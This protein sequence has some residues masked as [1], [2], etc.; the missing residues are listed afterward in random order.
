M[1]KAKFDGFRH[2]RWRY[3]LKVMMMMGTSPQKG[4]PSGLWAVLLPRRRRNL[5]L[6]FRAGSVEAEMF[7]QYS[8]TSKMR[9]VSC[10]K[11]ADWKDWWNW[12]LKFDWKYSREY[13]TWQCYRVIVEK[14][15]T[16][17][18]AATSCPVATSCNKEKQ[19]KINFFKYYQVLSSIKYYTTSYNKEKQEEIPFSSIIT[20]YNDGKLI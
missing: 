16:W 19:E 14:Q 2:W 6:G 1:K 13:L 9:E 7:L 15:E 5:H 4:I 20:F 11:C 10:P 3:K 18:F 17:N 12:K 8:K